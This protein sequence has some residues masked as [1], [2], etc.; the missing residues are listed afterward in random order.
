[1][2]SYFKI[3]S[4]YLGKLLVFAETSPGHFGAMIANDTSTKVTT[5]SGTTQTAV[6]IPLVGDTY[7]SNWYAYGQYEIVDR[8]VLI[9]KSNSSG[10]PNYPTGGYS[11]S[12]GSL[13]TVIDEHGTHYGTP[14]GAYHYNYNAAVGVLH[15]TTDSGW[16]FKGWK[17]T[18]SYSSSSSYYGQVLSKGGTQSGKEYTFDEN[19]TDAVVA[20]VGGSSSYPIT[21]E[22]LYEAQTYTIR[23]DAN[24]GSNPPADQTA[25]VGANWTCATGTPTKSYKRFLGWSKSDV[26]TSASYVGGQTY[27]SLTS[28]AG[29]TVTL[30]A[31]WGDSS[32][33]VTF[34]ANGGSVS[35]SSKTVTLGQ[36]YGTLPTPTYSGR[37]F[38]GWFTS[39]SGGSQVTAST[40]VTNAS[41]HTLYA[42]WTTQYVLKYDANGG[43]GAPSSQSFTS[44]VTI[45]TKRPT[46]QYRNFVGWSANSSATTASYFGGQT[47]TFTGNVTLY[48]VWSDVQVTV[49]FNANGGTVSPSSKTV[50]VGQTY[51]TLPTPSR[52]GYVFFGWYTATTGGSVVVSS[53][54]VTNSAN[55]TI[56]A[57]W[58]GSGG[59]PLVYDPSSQTGCYFR[60][61]YLFGDCGGLTVEGMPDG[62]ALCPSCSY[63]RVA[64]AKNT[65]VGY[66]CPSGSQDMCTAYNSNGM[67]VGITGSIGGSSVRITG[68]GAAGYKRPVRGV[69]NT[70]VYSPNTMTLVFDVDALKLR[71]YK[72]YG[73]FVAKRVPW[74]TGVLGKYFTGMTGASLVSTAV[75]F[76][77]TDG[78]YLG[79]EESGGWQDYAVVFIPLVRKIDYL[80]IFNPNGGTIPG[81]TYF[82]RVYRDETYGELPTPVRDGYAFAG[83]FTAETGGTKVTSSSY[84]TTLEDHT[85]FAHWTPTSVYHV[86]T[87]NPCGGTVSPSSRS[88]LEGAAY[89]TL[90]TPSRSHYNFAGWFTGTVS[91]SQVTSSTIMGEHDATIYAR[92]SATEVL[93][94]FNPNGGSVQEPSRSVRWG[95]QIGKLPTPEFPGMSF[96][97]WFTSAT[98]G[99]EITPTTVP[100]S[101]ATYYAH[102]TDGSAVWTIV[103]YK[104]KLETNG[105]AVDASYGE[106]KYQ[107]GVAK[108]LPTSDQVTRS[109]YRFGGWY[110]KADFSGSAQTSIPATATGTRTFYAKWV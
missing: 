31:V 1:M 73:W 47:Y 14:T 106:L 17:V 36:A 57:V 49:S 19:Y 13:V 81:G 35:P 75:S 18:L 26:A 29:S 74:S 63:V 65:K 41:N 104:I 8:G 48:A 103:K 40:T 88:V 97:G 109:G 45:S 87:F 77:L 95:S 59:Y 62:V 42:H 27:A 58:G 90:P 79:C 71:G 32:C 66:V 108:A 72:P 28:T 101:S 82:K 102:W 30:Y 56:Y 38:V 50:T 107:K 64:E 83:W 51:G 4:S 10:T 39:S 67:E 61:L 89:G 46:F 94:T 6:A 86:L 44:S 110:L 24:G 80:V 78:Q 76:T 16:K 37:T 54:Q 99:T 60:T 53:T 92:W 15:N 33:T 96:V 2:Y 68:S 20:Q 85:L 93:I 11:T 70:C 84:V 98:G 9:L 91:G 22:A 23:Y 55:H 69:L 100:S 3:T 43:E 105:G 12:S 5:T 21:I 25:T 7:V 34:N 52:Y